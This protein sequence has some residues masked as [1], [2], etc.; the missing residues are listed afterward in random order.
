[1]LLVNPEYGKNLNKYASQLKL[2]KKKDRRN[3]PVFLRTFQ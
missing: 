1:M 2:R 3:T